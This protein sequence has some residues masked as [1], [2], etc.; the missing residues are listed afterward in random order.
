MN[1]LEIRDLTMRFG[2]LT[3]VNK[4]GIGVDPGLIFSVIGPN[5]AGKTTVFNAV[6]GVYE[7]TEGDV[8]F[9]GTTLRKAFSARVGIGIALI[10]LLSG[11]LLFA[12]IHLEPIW[13][14]VIAAN[15]KFKQPFPWGEAAAS[16]FRFL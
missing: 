3:A 9:E 5:G 1:V 7:P 15:Y 2:G 8:L 16:F 11:A 14:A 6:T 4:V 10:A 13:K 12:V